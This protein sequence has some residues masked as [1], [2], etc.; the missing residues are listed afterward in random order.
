MGIF[1]LYKIPN[2]SDEKK[3]NVIK[4]E[5]LK[6]LFGKYKFSVFLEVDS[7]DENVPLCCRRIQ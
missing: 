3:K 1:H 4:G 6:Q 2:K 7:N 5:N